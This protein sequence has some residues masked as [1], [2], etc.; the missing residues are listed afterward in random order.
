MQVLG[1]FRF[2]SA[3]LSSSHLVRHKNVP[4]NSTLIALIDCVSFKKD[5]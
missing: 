1:G 3:A 4:S 5:V 2:S